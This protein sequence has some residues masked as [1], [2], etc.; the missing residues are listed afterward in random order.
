MNPIVSFIIP[1]YNAEKFVAEAINSVLTC[2]YEVFEIIL[3]D[4]GSTDKSL[5]ICY[6][7]EKKSENIRIFRHPGGI[8][9]GVSFTRKLG[10]QE[11]KG[12]FVYFLDA[13]DILFPGIIDQYV[14]IFNSFHDVILVHGEI[15]ILRDASHYSH[16]ME[17]GFFLGMSDRKYHLKD[18]PYYLKSN[19]ICT[20]TVCIRKEALIDINFNYDQVFPLAEDWL[21]FTLLAQ[22]GCF[23]YIARPVIKYR[24]HEN[25]V[26]FIAH[27]KGQGYLNYNLIEYYLCLMARTTNDALREEAKDHLFDLINELYITYQESP[28]DKGKPGI[29]DQAIP[30]NQHVMLLKK[31]IGNLEKGYGYYF[32]FFYLFKQFLWKLFSRK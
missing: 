14:N 31:K 4:D 29:M 15:T 28:G 16:K 5:E 19:R 7:F 25:S 24:V 11:A 12:E 6:S 20:S 26:T 17:P 23:Y 2:G 1:V 27:Q 9:K 10:I 30:L 18:E 13:D 8:N 22:K 3:V 21:L 32:Y